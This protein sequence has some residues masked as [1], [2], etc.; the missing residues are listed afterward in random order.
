MPMTPDL[1]QESFARWL[2]FARAGRIVQNREL[3]SSR[4]AAI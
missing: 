2:D 1:A 4:R 3:F